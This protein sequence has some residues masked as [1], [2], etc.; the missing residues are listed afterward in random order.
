M[1]FFCEEDMVGNTLKY[2]KDKKMVKTHK[3]LRY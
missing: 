2:L 1:F 3:G